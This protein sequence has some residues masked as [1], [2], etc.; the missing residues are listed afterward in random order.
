MALVAIVV[1]TALLATGCS[2]FDR[3]SRYEDEALKIPYELCTEGSYYMECFKYVT[4]DDCMELTTKH[5][6][7]CMLSFREQSGP[8]DPKWGV[9]WRRSMLACVLTPYSYELLIF[10]RV[11]CEI[12][13][14]RD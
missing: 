11:D 12:E 9:T 8:F 4:W 13:P 7:E 6:A 10:Y 1:V 3:R 5:V 2:K 14:V